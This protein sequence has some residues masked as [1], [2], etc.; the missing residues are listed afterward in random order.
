MAVLATAFLPWSMYTSGSGRVTAVDPNERLQ[1]INA[2]V[3]GLV[4]RWHVSEGT[5]V[6]KGAPIVDLVDMDTS[7]IGRV[8]SERKSAVD[9]VASSELALKTAEINLDRQRRLLADGL[10]A[11]KEYEKAK[12]EVSKLAVEL[13]KA[14]ATLFKAETQFSRQSRQSV[15]APRDGTVLRILRGAG[16][17]VIKSGDP[18]LIFAPEVS[19]PAVELWVSGDD[20]RFTQ[21]GQPVRIQFEGWP[22]VQVPGWPSVAIGTFSGKVLLVDHATLSNGKFRILVEPDEL[23]WPSTNFLRLN[24]NSRGYVYLGQTFVAKELWRKLNNFPP[25][26]TLFQEELAHL[27]TPAPDQTAAKV[28]PGKTGAGGADK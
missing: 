21:Q 12:I 15:V 5:R 28:A 11:R 10:A 13:S 17:Q 23:G 16:N 3:G 14:Q 1:E 24:A 20:M 22:A 7:L 18:L 25:S 2:P 4:Q 9:A 27:T 26:Q 6:E 8:D 19:S